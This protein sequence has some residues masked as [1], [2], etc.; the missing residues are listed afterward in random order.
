MKYTYE[1]VLKL[2]IKEYKAAKAEDLHMSGLANLYNTNKDVSE[3]FR[4]LGEKALIKFEVDIL[5]NIYYIS[6]TEKGISYFSER[7]KERLY[8][9]VPVTIS[10]LALIVAILSLLLDVS[11]LLM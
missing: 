1:N 11:E 8:F 4:I 10:I 7:R 6:L 2:L 9:W 3:A 5:G